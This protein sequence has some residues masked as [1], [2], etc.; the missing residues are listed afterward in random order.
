MNK[1]IIVSLLLL[2]A[3]LLAGQINDKS[4][5]PAKTAPDYSGMYTF[6]REGEFVQVTV[7]EA[8][9]VTGFVSRYG[10]LE[11]DKG[12]FLD[13]FFKEGKLDGNKIGF[14]TV[15][16]HGVWFEFKGSVDRG[17]GKNMGD[18]AYFVLKGTLTES[19]M[20]ESKKV[21]S[22]TRDVEFKSFPQ[23]LGA[24]PGKQD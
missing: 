7:E 15:T 3:S 13:H 24:T 12:T 16:V 5:P 11:S 19:R 17:P 9:R 6:L 20:D 2:T 18:E 8:G 4:P 14:T 1:R 21:S 22:K 10:D 23:D